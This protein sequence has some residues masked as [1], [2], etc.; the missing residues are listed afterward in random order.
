MLND[1]RVQIA[2]YQPPMS[3]ARIYARDKM[4]NARISGHYQ[5]NHAFM[6]LRRV[7]RPFASASSKNKEAKSVALDLR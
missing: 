6:S 4:L 3:G 2:H 1:L 7:E 5:C